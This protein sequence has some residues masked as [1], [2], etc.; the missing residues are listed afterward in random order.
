[1]IEEFF[2]EKV[3]PLYSIGTKYFSRFSALY[4]SKS[5]AYSR[6][7]RYT[8]HDLTEKEMSTM[9]PE[10][11]FKASDSDDGGADVDEG[12]VTLSE[13]L[14]VKRSG[15]R[16]FSAILLIALL[17][18]SSCPALYNGLQL[19]SACAILFNAT[20]SSFHNFP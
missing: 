9:T 14:A 1:L 2:R 19:F 3:S 8:A 4:N 17:Y 5:Y 18:S 7:A 20:R 6:R 12:N 15:C 11:R 13:L 10:A 16:L